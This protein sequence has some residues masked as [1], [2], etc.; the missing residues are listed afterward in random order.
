[1]YTNS[2]YIYR[3]KKEKKQQVSQHKMVAKLV[4][5]Y[6]FQLIALVW[7]E[8][9]LRQDHQTYMQNVEALNDYDEFVKNS[10]PL[11][12]TMGYNYCKC[13]EESSISLTTFCASVLEEHYSR[14]RKIMNGISVGALNRGTYHH[15]LTID[16]L[17]KSS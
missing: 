8:C 4:I 3:K 11:Q 12:N 16:T 1:M 15:I 6:I 10:N 14:N 2:S 7:S 17:L 9:L 13:N 5:T